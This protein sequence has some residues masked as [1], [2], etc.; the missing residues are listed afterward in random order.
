MRRSYWQPVL[1]WTRDALLAG[2][3]VSPEDLDLL[4]VTDDPAEAVRVVVDC[5][6]ESCSHVV[7]AE[8]RKAD[9]Q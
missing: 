5:Y 1:D 2:G 9:A 7:P 3:Y 8:S 6:R 4:T